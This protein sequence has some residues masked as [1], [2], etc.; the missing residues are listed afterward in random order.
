MPSFAK[1]PSTSGNV[2]LPKNELP[3]IEISSG[4][5]SES[6]V[7]EIAMIFG[8]SLTLSKMSFKRV[9]FFVKLRM[10]Q[11]NIDKPLFLISKNLRPHCLTLW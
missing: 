7:S 6:F 1:N 10:L 11:C 5:L 2:V 8:Y 4:L 9:K 3:G